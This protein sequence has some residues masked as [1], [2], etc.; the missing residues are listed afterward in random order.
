MS[1]TL[2]G[3]GLRVPKTYKLFIGGKFPRSESG[4]TYQ[5]RDV[6]GQLLANAALAMYRAKTSIVT[7]VCFYEGAMDEA[8]RVRRALAQDLI[9][10][11]RYAVLSVFD[12]PHGYP[13]LSRIAAF[14]P[15]VGGRGGWI[16]A[17][18]DLGVCDRRNLA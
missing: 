5:L 8:A 2:S 18:G 14:L 17:A 13:H 1:Q 12:A 9:A 3:P 16:A 4:R 6:G 7:R 15:S 11:M 10:T